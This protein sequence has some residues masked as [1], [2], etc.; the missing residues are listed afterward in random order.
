V[1]AD[2]GLTLN[3]VGAR[4]AAVLAETLELAPF[5][6]VLYS[7]DAYGLPELVYLG[8]RLWRNAVIEVLGDW[9]TG[10]HWS[11]QDAVR[12]ARMIGSENSTRLYGLV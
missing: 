1:Y 9:V 11:E 6:K 12:V 2:L 8:A 5:G 7:S 3:H 10:G 4:A